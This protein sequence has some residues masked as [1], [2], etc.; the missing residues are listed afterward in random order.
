MDKSQALSLAMSAAALIVSATAAFYQYKARQDTVAEEIKMELKMKL[1][2]ALLSPTELRMLSG[3]DERKD[4]SAVVVVTNIGLTIVR[5]SEVGFQDFDLPKI[6]YSSRGDNAKA[7]SPGEQAI[8]PA[9]EMVEITGQLTQ[10]IKLGESKSAHLFL[11]STKGNRFQSPA[12]IE[13]AK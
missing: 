6:F 10:D 9:D 11:V 3:V 13:V 12:V 2:D 1:D 5:L 4:L 7:L 8:F